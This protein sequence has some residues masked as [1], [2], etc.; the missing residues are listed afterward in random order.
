MTADVDALLAASPPVPEPAR[1]MVEPTSRHRRHVYA[2][3]ACTICLR[4][5]DVALTRRGRSSSRLGKD[6]ERRIQRVYGPTKVGQFGDAIDLVG[7]DFAWQS[8][9]TRTAPPRWLETVDEPR[10]LCP[11]DR[12][13]LALELAMRPILGPRSPLVIRSYVRQQDTREWIWVPAASWDAWHSGALPVTDDAWL[14]MSGAHF[15][16]VHGRDEP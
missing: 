15:L 4:P 1:T 2:D 8:K 7:R 16:A 13:T 11:P 9:S 12:Q 6:Q 5:Q 3:G 14:V 10:G